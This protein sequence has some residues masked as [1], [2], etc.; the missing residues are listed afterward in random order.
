MGSGS[1]VLEAG[2]TS[3]VRRLRTGVYWF[4]DGNCVGPE[5]R[6]AFSIWTTTKERRESPLTARLGIRLAVYS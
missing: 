4:Y 2:R 3:E 6:V 5:L 1:S